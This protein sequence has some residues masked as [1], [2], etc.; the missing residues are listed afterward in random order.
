MCFLFLKAKNFNIQKETFWGGGRGGCLV[1][2]E[3][4]SSYLERKLLMAS[5]H[6]FMYF[7]SWV[8]FFSIQFVFEKVAKSGMNVL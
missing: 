3:D 4:N 1:R 8:V 5:I 6:I 2:I 7:A